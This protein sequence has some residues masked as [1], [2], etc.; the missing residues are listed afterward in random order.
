MRIGKLLWTTFGTVSTLIGEFPQRA[1]RVRERNRG[2]C[3]H[4]KE[5][6]GKT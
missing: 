1:L 6:I 2:D 4:T 5:K 3:V